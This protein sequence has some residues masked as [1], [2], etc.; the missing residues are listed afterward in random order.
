MKTKVVREQKSRINVVLIGHNNGGKSTIAG[1]LLCKTGAFPPERIKQGEKE[2]TDFGQPSRK[3]SVLVD[4]HKR[5]FEKGR[6]HDHSVHKVETDEQVITLI[7]TPGTKKYVKN[8]I[9][10]TAMADAAI[11][12]V[13]ADED[14]EPLFADSK[15]QTREYTFLAGS[16]GLKQVICVVNKMDAC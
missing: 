11:L 13:T 6:N 9:T 8:M 7:N 2:A 3:F 5:E 14:F 16:Y 1:H 12:V 4:R 10:G 15:S